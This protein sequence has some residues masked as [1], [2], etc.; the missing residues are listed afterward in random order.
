MMRWAA[1]CYER[2]CSLDVVG[3]LLGLELLSPYEMEAISYPLCFTTTKI[4]RSR[5]KWS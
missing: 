5:C 4:Y 1:F 2:A 3:R